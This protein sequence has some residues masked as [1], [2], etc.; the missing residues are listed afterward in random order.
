MP[1]PVAV[2]VAVAAAAAVGAG[3]VA[4]GVGVGRVEVV[5]VSD[6]SELTLSLEV[7]LSEV[8]QEEIENRRLRSEMLASQPHGASPAICVDVL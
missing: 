3:A 4:V 6:V 1:V 5:E 8:V 7:A 2:A